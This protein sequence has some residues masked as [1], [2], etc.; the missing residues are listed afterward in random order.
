MIRPSLII[1]TQAFLDALAKKA[2]AF[3]V[4]KGFGRW[5]KEYERMEEAGL[6]EP[7]T[8][9]PHFND[10]LKGRSRLGFLQRQAIFYIGTQAFDDVFAL[11]TSSSFD[12]WIEDLDT[13]YTD[14]D[15]DKIEELDYIEA[16]SIAIAIN[17][18]AED[19]DVCIVEHETKQI[20]WRK[21]N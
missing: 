8:L 4:S 12:I 13:Y 18:D 16:L 15:G 3:K 9:R 14:E 11:I 10:Y 5:L 20:I 7:N 21:Q 6:F 2:N 1:D 17:K 19:Y